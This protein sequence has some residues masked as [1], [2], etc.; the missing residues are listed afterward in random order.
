[1]ARVPTVR[2]TETQKGKTPLRSGARTVEADGLGRQAPPG[3]VARLLG[4]AVG[5]DP[6]HY[7]FSLSVQTLTI[8]H[9][10]KAKPKAGTSKAAVMVGKAWTS[11]NGEARKPQ[12][13]AHGGK[14]N[15]APGLWIRRPSPPAQFVTVME[16][17]L[18]GA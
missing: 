2:T 15:R 4:R 5:P 9:P 7:L 14:P 8:A 12:R 11:G 17:Q 13:G 16:N 6:I 10:M 1:M 3:A 18:A